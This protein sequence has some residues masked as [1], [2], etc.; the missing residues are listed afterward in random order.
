M[1]DCNWTRRFTLIESG[2][3]VFV[4]THDGKKGEHH[5]HLLD[6]WSWI[7][8][9]HLPSQQVHGITLSGA[10]RKFRECVLAV[11]TVDLLDEAVGIWTCSGSD[12]DKFAMFKL[13]PVPSRVVRLPLIKQCIANIESRVIDMIKKHNIVVLQA[14]AACVGP[15]L[16]AVA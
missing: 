12:A 14:V 1:R 11:S 5:D 15:V 6:E 16:V 7:S 8:L 2:P 10:L 13:T 9:P 4:A 3:V